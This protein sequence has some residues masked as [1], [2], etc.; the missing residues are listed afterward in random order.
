M[1]IEFLNNIQSRLDTY[2]ETDLSSEEED[3]KI[4]FAIKNDLCNFIIQASN[5][6][7]KGLIDDSEY[8][9]FVN[10]ALNVLANNTGCKEDL[11][12]YDKIISRLVRGGHLSKDAFKGVLKESAVSR[13]L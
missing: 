5:E 10:S 9:F 1:D 3:F 8:N 13:W 2:Y 7:E 6:L 4:N 11:I 12:I